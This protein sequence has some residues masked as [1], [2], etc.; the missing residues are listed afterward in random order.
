MCYCVVHRLF[1]HCEICIK[2]TITRIVI[3]Q[4]TSCK[5]H[6]TTAPREGSAYTHD[7]NMS[8]RSPKGKISYGLSCEVKVIR[9]NKNKKKSDIGENTFRGCLTVLPCLTML[10]NPVTKTLTHTYE[11]L[12]EFPPDDITGVKW[13]EMSNNNVYHCT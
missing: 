2:Y 9:Q 7:H 3:G 5:K 10:T 4:I 6:K 13:L 8:R 12:V 1:S 11:I